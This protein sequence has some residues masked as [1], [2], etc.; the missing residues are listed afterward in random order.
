MNIQ[1]YQIFEELRFVIEVLAAELLLFLPAP[2]K[3]RSYFYPRL[4]ISSLLYFASSLL[5]FPIVTGIKSFAE[6]FP[7][8]SSFY[9]QWTQLIKYWYILLLFLSSGI[10]RFCFQASLSQ[11]MFKTALAWTIQHIEYVLVNE[12]IGVGLWNNTRQEHLAVYVLISVFSCAVLYF[13]FYLIFRKLINIE[14]D[15]PQSKWTPLIYAI[16][17]IALLQ[18]TFY[19]QRLFQ[20]N[21]DGNYNFDAG[22]YDVVVCLI[23]LFSQYFMLKFVNSI[24]EKKRTQLLY[25]ERER[26]LEQSIQ[27]IDIINQKSHDLKHQLN[28][29]KK[30]SPELQD[31]ALEEVYQNIRIYDSSFHT[32]NNI[33]NTILMEK[34]LKADKIN[35]TMTVIADGRNLDFI[36]DLDLYVLFG[37]ILDN[38]IEAVEKI[39]DI[40]SRIISLSVS[41]EA[42]FISIQESNY[43]S[44]KIKKLNGTIQTSK[45]DKN[46]HGYGIRSV[47]SIVKKYHGNIVINTPDQMFTLQILIPI[48]EKPIVPTQEQSVPETPKN[49]IN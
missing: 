4:I 38:A 17:L 41:Q 14:Y 23:F 22:I 5:Y 12:L 29:L 45:E 49:E 7:I 31:A 25:A 2:V 36:E 33:L 16:Y 15:G 43:F 32:K 27:N 34:K 13:L 1:G 39:D 30:M 18:V 37:N 6:I 10:L 42:N 24:A 21:R 20:G 48:V 26:Q 19:F 9:F 8:D 11:I 40:D 44:G 3:R 46:Y 47:K 35:A 28:A